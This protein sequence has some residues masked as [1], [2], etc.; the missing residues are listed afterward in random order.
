MPS[1]KRVTGMSIAKL[2]LLAGYFLRGTCAFLVQYLAKACFN[3]NNKVLTD[4]V[5]KISYTLD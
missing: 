3:N 1:C 4:D 5:S 2:M